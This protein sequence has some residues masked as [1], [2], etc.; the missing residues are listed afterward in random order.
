MLISPLID[1]L[2]ISGSG[3]LVIGSLLKAI[4]VATRYNPHILGFSSLDF[5][6]MTMV[7]WMFALVLAARTWVQ[8]N[9]PLLL[10]RRRERMQQEARWRVAE[11]EFD[12]GEVDDAEEGREVP[13]V[14]AGER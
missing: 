7:C 3:F 5:L 2:V 12:Y 10:R 11:N 13:G 14:A 8:I 1:L 9:E 4:S 6:L